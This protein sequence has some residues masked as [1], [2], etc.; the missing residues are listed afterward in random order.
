MLPVEELLENSAVGVT[1]TP[2]PDVFLQ[3]QV[4][5]LVL[6][7]KDRKKNKKKQTRI[8]IRIILCQTFH[9]RDVDYCRFDYF[10][11]FGPTKRKLLGHFLEFLWLLWTHLWT[12][13]GHYGRWRRLLDVGATII[14][15][16]Q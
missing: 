13:S 16:F 6:Y 15:F 10:S 7:A 5:H 1:S 9:C 12:P 4:F 14:P 3:T 11:V 8:N 2:Y